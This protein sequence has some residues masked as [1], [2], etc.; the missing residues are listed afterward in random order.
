MAFGAP[1]QYGLPRNAYFSPGPNAD[2]ESVPDGWEPWHDEPAGVTV[3]V[4]RPDVF[5]GTDLPAAC[6]PTLAI[7]PARSRGP[8]GRPVRGRDA[9]AWT[10]QLL[11]EPELVMKRETVADR[12]VAVERGR[13]WMARFAAGAVPIDG[14]ELSAPE[15]GET[16][17]SLLDQEV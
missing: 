17:V 6:M 3:F 5:D 14:Y 15:Y 12:S 1:C 9:T 4:Y 2:V 10:V 11:L 7:R 16:L 13:N 8:R